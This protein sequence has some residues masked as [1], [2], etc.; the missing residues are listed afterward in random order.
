MTARGA[1]PAALFART[2][3]ADV[4]GW[5]V[6]RQTAWSCKSGRPCSLSQHTAH[7]SAKERMYKMQRTP[8]TCGVGKSQSSC[9]LHAN[10]GP[11]QAC[12]LRRC[13]D[14]KRSAPPAAGAG[15]WEALLRTISMPTIRPDPRTSPT[16]SCLCAAAATA[17]CQQDHSQKN[18]T[19]SPLMP[20]CSSSHSIPTASKH[21]HLVCRIAWQSV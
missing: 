5:E 15:V 4:D 12:T 6:A 3:R 2:P 19:Q 13:D 17:L 1:L 21:C 7:S 8:A 14:V 11:K 18:N 16:H 9:K 20:L 10:L